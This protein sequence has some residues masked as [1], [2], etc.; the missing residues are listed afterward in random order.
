MK[1]GVPFTFKVVKIP[2]VSQQTLNE[3]KYRSGWIGRNTHLLW[4]SGDKP[5]LSL[6]LA[7]SNPNDI[8]DTSKDTRPKFDR[9][10]TEE[11]FVVYLV[12]ARFGNHAE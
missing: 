9:I 2:N 10:Y 12:Y 7:A 8:H 5:I 1:E 3:I 6:K 11:R 4:S